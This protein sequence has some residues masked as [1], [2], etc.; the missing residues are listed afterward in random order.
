[1]GGAVDRHQARDRRRL[2]RVSGSRHERAR[3]R[4]HAAARADGAAGGV[5]EARTG[6]TLGRVARRDQQDLNGTQ[7]TVRCT[8]ESVKKFAS[9]TRAA[10]TCY[11]SMRIARKEVGSGKGGA[12]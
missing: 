9:M 11:G 5:A 7:G 10:S 2:D 3:Q 8:S 12:V 4:D 1:M 6:F